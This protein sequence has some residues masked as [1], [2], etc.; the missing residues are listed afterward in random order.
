MIQSP[1]CVKR[2][3]ETLEQSG[4]EAYLVGGCVR[5]MAMGRTPH[6]WDVTTDAWPDAVQALFP[7]T[8]PTGLRHGTVTVVTEEGHVEVTTMRREGP[9]TDRRRPEQVAYVTDLT[10]DLSRRDFTINAMAVS[11]EGDLIDPFGGAL[12]IEQEIIRCVGDPAMRFSEDAL[13]MFRA[14]RF[15]A[16]LGFTIHP[17][18]LRGIRAFAHLAEALSA[19]R[20]RDEVEHMLCSDRPGILADVLEIGLLAAYTTRE[21]AN[22]MEVDRLNQVNP[23]RYYRWGAFAATL[24]KSGT[25]T[26]PAKFLRALRLD[27][28]TIGVA[29]RGAE[30]AQSGDMPVSAVQ[31]KRFLAE[32]GVDTIRCMAEV[33]AFFGCGAGISQLEAVL[34]SG[35][36]FSLGQLTV[37]GRDLIALGL[38]GTEIGRELERLL[39][40]VIQY[41]ADNRQDLLLALV[42][43]P[44][45]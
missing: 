2:V 37:G 23:H 27:N 19:E 3:L 13:R 8:A 25:I 11:R 20:V 22:R 40:Y 15:S 38:S 30:L 39:D 21:P 45:E 24:K 9:Y 26:A 31:C 12:D 34:A 43:I 42:R 36:C 14:L 1:D 18:T 16:K 5:D 35:D 32:Y 7:R 29:A 33:A 4:Y 44:Q 6:D 41:P 28:K 10:E 17:E